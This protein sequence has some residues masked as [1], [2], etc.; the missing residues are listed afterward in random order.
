[1]PAPSA[2]WGCPVAHD[3]V[4]ALDCPA[5][6]IPHAGTVGQSLSAIDSGG[7]DH[8]TTGAT[9]SLK[10]LAIRVLARDK[11]RDIFRDTAALV[12]AETVPVTIA[13]ETASGTPAR[14]SEPGRGAP[15]VQSNAFAGFGLR[16]PPSWSGATTI[17]LRGCLC[18]CCGSRRWWREAHNARGW[19]CWAC[20]PPDHLPH[21]SVA[22]VRT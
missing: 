17:P 10:A 5:V 7:T 13:V 21:N 8:R 6:P 9:P 19:R 1:V 3:V 22:H 2:L 20:H 16:R 18:S 15:P 4:A 11:A 14:L 12:P